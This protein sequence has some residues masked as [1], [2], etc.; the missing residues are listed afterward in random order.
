MHAVITG[1]SSGIGEALAKAFAAE[2]Y[3]VTL[4]ARRRAELD[5]VKATLGA[6][7]RAHVIARDVSDLDGLA[8]ILE[9][10]RA[11]HGPIDVL[12]NNAG[13]QIVAPTAGVPIA[14]GEDLMRIDLIAPMRLTQLA[15]PEMIARKSGAIVDVSSLAALAPVPGMFH[16]A[17]AKAGLAAA[18]ESLRAEVKPHGVHVLTVYPGPV[19]TPMAARAS[20]RYEADP[21]KGMPW[22]TPDPLARLVIRALKKRSPRVIYPRAYTVARFLPWLARCVTDFFAPTPKALTE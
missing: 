22:G 13:V 19:H 6:S 5:R 17:A 20:D 15:L 4:V 10:A 1:A 9:E 14:R 8:G 7:A 11:A 16:Y 3:A 2:G 12:V 21:T 18:S